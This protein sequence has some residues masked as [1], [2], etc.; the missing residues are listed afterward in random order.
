[1]KIHFIYVVV[2]AI[3]G[4]GCLA[5]AESEAVSAK[6]IVAIE[7]VCAWP[8]LTRMR[9]RIQEGLQAQR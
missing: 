2:L 4:A 7:D 1:M 8:N 5:A 6:H 9:K 3:A